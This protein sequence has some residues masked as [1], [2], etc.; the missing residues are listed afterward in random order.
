[1]PREFI[2]RNIFTPVMKKVKLEK[3]ARKDFDQGTV[4]IQTP[5]FTISTDYGYFQYTSL[6]LSSA[7]TSIFK[8]SETLLHHG[9]AN[10][11][12]I[13]YEFSGVT[14]HTV[15]PGLRASGSLGRPG[16]RAAGQ[17]WAAGRRAVAGRGPAFSKTRKPSKSEQVARKFV[18][19]SYVVHRNSL[20]KSNDQTGKLD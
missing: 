10:H 17:S 3:K 13:T 8:I 4:V 1:M 6:Q 18:H 12:T 2:A 7:E 9:S 14:V 19:N 16:P 5:S 11:C 15:P 20:K